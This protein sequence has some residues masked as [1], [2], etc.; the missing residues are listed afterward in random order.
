ML[1]VA[2]FDGAYEHASVPVPNNP[3]LSVESYEEERPGG[4]VDSDISIS[5]S[6]ELWIAGQGGLRRN[7][8]GSRLRAAEQRLDFLTSTLA[9]RTRAAFLRALVAREGV[10][11]AQQIVAANRNLTDFSERRLEAGEAN[12][13]EVNIA[14][15][16]L[17]RAESLLAQAEN[18]FAQARLLLA[19][20]LWLDPAQNFDLDGE[21]NPGELEIPD[22]GQLMNRAVD[23]RGDLAAASELV[24]A[25][26]EELKL[27]NRQLIPNLTVFA[28][29]NSDVN[30]D[31][32]VLAGVSFELPVFHRFGGERKQAAA[33]LDQALL[34]QDSVHLAIRGQ[35][36][37]AMAFY[38]AASR[39]LTAVSEEVL[40]SA[41][42]NLELTRTAFEAGEVN[43]VALSTAQDVLINT[44]NEYLQALN[45]LVT[46][47]SEL[48]RSTGGILI[49]SN[50]DPAG[51]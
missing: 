17:G 24:I 3:R 15:I 44:R 28:V 7:A 2:R 41:N 46:A 23:R 14:R 27:A 9:A 1:D 10:E 36:L 39:S 13:L 49:M 48:E 35:V 11:S 6:Q 42:D 34:E 20:L 32:E 47:G 22:Q 12:Q 33:Q 43:A 45:D 50:S 18:D 40:N 4:Q 21:L 25:A 19:E 26:Q 51:N 16:G 31:R 29:T 8:A 37:S 38:R 5:L 30:I